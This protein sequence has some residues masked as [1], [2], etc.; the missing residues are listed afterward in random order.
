MSKE[1]FAYEWF[2]QQLRMLLTPAD[3]DEEM[4]DDELENGVFI[5]EG[6]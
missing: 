6:G 1:D 4:E 2:M 5:A 3:D